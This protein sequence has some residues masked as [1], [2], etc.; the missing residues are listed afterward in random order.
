[1]FEVSNFLYDNINWGFKWIEVFIDSTKGF[2]TVNHQF[3][4]SKLEFC[5]ITDVALDVLKPYIFERKQRV[6]IGNSS[7]YTTVNCQYRF[8]VLC[9]GLYYF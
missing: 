4:I 6:R 5:G 3:L 8:K 1:M 9:W 7:S 2:D